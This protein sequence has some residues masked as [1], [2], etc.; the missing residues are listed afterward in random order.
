MKRGLPIATVI[1]LVVGVCAFA[2][3]ASPV[4]ATVPAAAIAAGGSHSCALTVA[5]GVQCWGQNSSGQ[6]G[7]GTTTHRFEP[8]D[9]VGL[10]SGV[11]AVTSPTTR[12]RGL[13]HRAPE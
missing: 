3:F 11:A 13:R 10:T 5:G 8:V 1:G 6:L 7:D 4:G 12:R 2:P 9:V